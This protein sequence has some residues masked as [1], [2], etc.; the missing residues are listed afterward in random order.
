MNEREFIWSESK[1][2][3]NQQKHKISFELARRAFADPF[4][5]IEQDRIDDGEYRWQTIGLVDG[6]MLL[7]VAHMIWD[8]EDGTEI[9]RIIS[10]RHADPKERKRYERRRSY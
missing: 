4:A 10:A 6:H 2:R 1:N 9:I 8:E 5:T 7:I 3:S